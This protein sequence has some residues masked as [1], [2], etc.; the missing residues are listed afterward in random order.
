M[1]LLN[2]SMI[3]LS[4]ALSMGFCSCNDSEDSPIT[5]EQ[6]RE[7]FEAIPLTIEQKG[8]V[9]SQNDAAFKLFKAVNNASKEDNV[10]SVSYTHR[11]LPTI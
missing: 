8:I 3:I 9:E 11:T 5:N 7:Y 1:K 10:F 2:R 4:A 6:G